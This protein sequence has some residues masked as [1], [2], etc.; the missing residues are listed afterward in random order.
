MESR[1][2]AIA[3]TIGIF[4]FLVLA[5]ACS[6]SV[7]PKEDLSSLPAPAPAAPRCET[8]PV[9]T[10]T[11][12]PMGSGLAAC[13]DLAGDLAR[14]RRIQILHDAATGRCAYSGS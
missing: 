1:L 13:F 14:Q 2:R 10:P 11:A 6:F 8:L 5:A 9:A 12:C 3:A 7:F 4:G